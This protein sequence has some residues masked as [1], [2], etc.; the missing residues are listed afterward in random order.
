[1]SKNARHD[2]SRHHKPKRDGTLAILT[3]GKIPGDP[4]ELLATSEIFG[5]RA[6]DIAVQHGQLTHVIVDEGDGLRYFHLWESEHGMLRACEQLRSPGRGQ[7]EWRQ[8]D[9]VYH[10]IHT[11]PTGA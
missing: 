4:H 2:T 1:M 11:T 6:R 3:S 10:E 7:Q 8:W 9:V 5:G